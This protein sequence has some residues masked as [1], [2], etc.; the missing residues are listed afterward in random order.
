MNKTIL[1]I[2]DNDLNMKLFNDLLTSR[3]YATLC[4]EDGLLGLELARRH[5]PDLV[6][7]DIQLP[8]VS[9]LEVTRQIRAD[10]DIAHLPIL[11]VSAF[12]MRGDAERIVAGGCD[13]Y[14]AKPFAPTRFL[15]EI[16]DLVGAASQ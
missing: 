2:E 14:L 11:A 16:D 15:S 1:I 12:A 5:R 6:V 9:G 4:A 3:G 7:M 8:D 13:R 10:R